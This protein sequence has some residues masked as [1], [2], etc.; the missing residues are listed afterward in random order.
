MLSIKQVIF[1]CICVIGVWVFGF[2]F[3]RLFSD[4][5]EN[6]KDIVPLSFLM[7]TSQIILLSY[8]FSFFWDTDE[9]Y[10]F[11]CLDY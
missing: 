10:Y 7:G 4:K 1:Y 2:P 6:T 5:K 11:Y 9:I 3:A 8:W